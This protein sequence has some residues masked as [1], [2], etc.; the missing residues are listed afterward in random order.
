MIVTNKLKSNSKKDI[1]KKNIIKRDKHDNS[2]NNNIFNIINNNNLKKLCE[3][4][5][6]DRSKI[7]TLNND[8]LSPLHISIIKG[9]IEI[10]NVLL[11]NGAN[12][13]ILSSKKK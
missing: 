13:N 10:I 7:N 12:P 3:L 11:L 2:T 9:N 1:F 4:L 8:G 6:K 5:K